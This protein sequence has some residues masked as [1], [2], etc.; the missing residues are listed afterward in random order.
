M[1]SNAKKERN[2]REIVIQAMQI[3][4]DIKYYY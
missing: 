1:H 2:N 4:K 3:L